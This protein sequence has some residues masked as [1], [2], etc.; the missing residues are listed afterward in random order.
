MESLRRQLAETQG[1]LTE[2]DKKFR[3]LSVEHREALQTWEL[4]REAYETRVRQLEAENQRLRRTPPN[5]KANAGGDTRQPRPPTRPQTQSGARSP[6]ESPTRRAKERKEVRSGGSTP[7]AAAGNETVT[8]T[9]SRMQEIDSQYQQ[10]TTKLAEKTKLCEVLRTKLQANTLKTVPA[11]ELTDEQ[12]ITRWNLLSERIRKLTLVRLNAQIPADLVSDKAR[13][14]FNQLSP[15]WKAYISRQAL[16]C[17]LLR[18]LIW[19]YLMRFFDVFCRAWGRDISNTVVEVSALF[20]SKISEDEHKDWRI[21]TAALIDKIYHI[22]PSI[23]DEYTTN[24]FEAINPFAA[25]TDTDGL[26]TSVREIVQMAAELSAK[27][28]RSRFVVLMSDEPGSALTQGFPYKEATMEMQG[29]LGTQ[30]MVD[31]MITPCLLKKEYDYSVLVKAD[32]TC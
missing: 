7:I 9:R 15:N 4:E 25:G 19:R 23:V 32:V 1:A 26:K 12:V 11:F 24:V 17:Y 10:V 31:L 5:A 2:R 13:K 16:T 20:T 3:Q 14:E 6:S 18:A 27:F 30:A 21:H 22:N 8:I 28:S 29:K